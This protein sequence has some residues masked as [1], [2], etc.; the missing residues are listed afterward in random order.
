MKRLFKWDLIVY[1]AIKRTGDDVHQAMQKGFSGLHH[2]IKETMMKNFHPI[3][4]KKNDSG[5][6]PQL[7]ESALVGGAQNGNFPA[8]R[9]APALYK[10]STLDTDPHL[11]EAGLSTP[12]ERMLAAT[13]TPIT[14]SGSRQL[15]EVDKVRDLGE[16][17]KIAAA[18]G[19][20]TE[21]LETIKEIQEKLHEHIEEKRQESRKTFEVISEAG[22]ADEHKRSELLRLYIETRE[23]LNQLDDEFINPLETSLGDIKT[24]LEENIRSLAPR[25]Q[26]VVLVAGETSAGKSSVINLILGEE[27]LP[28]AVL[29]TTSTMFELKYDKTPM[30]VIHFNDSRETMYYKL[31]GPKESFQEQINSLV[32]EKN[33]RGRVSPYKKIELFLPHPLFQ[34]R[35]II[36]DSPGVGDNN[37]M[38]EAVLNY[39]P[40]A[41][42]FIYVINSTNA[43]GVQEDRLGKLL[44]NAASCKREARMDL[45]L[46]AGCALFVCN[47]WDEIKPHEVEEVKLEQIKRLTKKLGGLDPHL[48][49]VYLSCKDAQLAQEYGV[50][51]SDFDDLIRGIS[52]LL[53]SSMQNNLDIYTRQIKKA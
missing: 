16:L 43:G 35:V 48:Q 14:G 34:E 51:R 37:A 4:E 10:P 3:V 25:D 13:L 7:T 18:V 11:P 24:A 44:S 30:V 23:I 42:C 8:K 38:N 9:R 36:V 19:V 49:V 41:F 45:K 32:S 5:T 46:F 40:N 12:P 47:K 21:N 50:I 1:Q 6:S 31:V 28:S 2:A 53:V 26:Y 27:I 20:K 17:C 15:Q 29:G 39:L 22:K 52:N 33:E